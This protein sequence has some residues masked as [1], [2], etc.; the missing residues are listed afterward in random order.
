LDILTGAEAKLEI[1]LESAGAEG[2]GGHA[3]ALVQDPSSTWL[4]NAAETASC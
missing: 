2:Q 3:A 1:P 4:R